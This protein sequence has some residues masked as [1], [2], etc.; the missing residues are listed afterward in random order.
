MCS[1]GFAGR[2]E[3]RR[4]R[5]KKK[6]APVIDQGSACVKHLQ[7]KMEL[8][9]AGNQKGAGFGSDPTNTAR[10]RKCEDLKDLDCL[11][12]RHLCSS[13]KTNVYALHE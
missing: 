11:M 2:T 13:T 5:K 3:A 6:G 1:E 8:H 9:A 10:Q 4:G 7:A 12:S